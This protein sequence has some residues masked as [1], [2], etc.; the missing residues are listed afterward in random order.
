MVLCFFPEMPLSNQRGRIPTLLEQLRARDGFRF[1]PLPFGPL[2]KLHPVAHPGFVPVAPRQGGRP[3][4]RTDRSAHKRIHQ[5]STLGNQAIHVR[6]H[7]LLITRSPKRPRRLVIGADKKNIRAPISLRSAVGNLLSEGSLPSLPLSLPGLPLLSHR[8]QPTSGLGSPR[9][10]R[11]GI[12]ILNLLQHR[13]GP[14]RLLSSKIRLLLEILIETVKLD[15]LVLKSAQLCLRMLHHQLPITFPHRFAS[16]PIITQRR[17][18]KRSIRE[19]A[20]PEQHG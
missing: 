13:C 4:G 20:L 11:V 6:R 19:I 10:L 8:A 15:L 18:E 5:V 12:P 9:P 14:F 1:N 16:R 17:P 3:R 7:R 2:A